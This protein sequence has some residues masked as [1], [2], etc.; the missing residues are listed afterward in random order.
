MQPIELYTPEYIVE[1]WD[2]NDVFVADISKYISTSLRFQEEL[3]DV[4]DLSFS[5]D[6]VQFENLCKSIG[7]RPL[8]LIEPYRTDIKIRRNNEY[9]L[10]A[11]VV[12]VGVSFNNQ[13]TNKI[14]VSCTGYLNHLK[15]RIT[16][17]SYEKMTYAEIARNLVY[18]TQQPYNYIKNES[19]V[20]GIAGWQSVDAGYM[21]WDSN[22]GHTGKGSGFVSVTTGP[23]SFGGARW[24]HPMQAGVEYTVSFWVK[25]SSAE[26]N[27][28]IV[29]QPGLSSFSTPVTDS[30]WNYY[31]FTW[32]QPVDGSSVDIKFTN[33]TDFWL[34]E[35]TL[36]DN[37]EDET[38]R[39]FGIELGTD[40]ASSTQ[41][42][43][44]VRNYDLQNVKDAIINLTKLESDN[45]DFKFDANKVFTTHARLGSDKPQVELVYPQNITSISVD[46][47]AQTLYN[48]VYGVGS[49][50]GEERIQF[51][52]LDPDS[53]LTYRVRET[54]ETFNSVEILNTLIQNTYGSLTEQKDMYSRINVVLENNTL[55]LNT[56]N[57]GDAIY[58]RVDGSTYVDFVNGLYRIVGRSVT[59][60]TNME[61]SVTLSLQAWE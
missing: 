1:V 3:N 12:S 16:N 49:G 7:V 34:D 15:D 33:N 19:F 20:K 25:A 29:Y 11:H 48:K 44:R 21:I 51:D 56:V 32:T 13:E 18:D 55:D 14:E 42:A 57:V 60:S 2:I 39:S 59:V 54:V 22:T 47:D 30:N 61:E 23:N 26:G 40:F 50:M 52:I 17:K 41:Q 8:N 58:V 45:F 37:I 9:I 27:V 4:D 6:L 35:V 53:S 46:L 36:S 10:G 5:I 31:T 28:Y 38:R 43:D 24:Q